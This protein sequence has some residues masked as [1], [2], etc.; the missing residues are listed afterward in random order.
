MATPLAQTV[1]FCAGLV[2]SLSAL[3]GGLDYEVRHA[4]RGDAGKVS[5]VMLHAV[6]AELVIFGASNAETGISPAVLTA[7]TGRTAY[8]LAVDGTSVEQYDALL[9]EYLTYGR[10][11]SLVI[12]VMSAFALQSHSAP[13][14]PGEY[15]PHIYNPFVYESMARFDSTDAWRARYVPFYRFA[16]YDDKYYKAALLSLIESPPVAT[17]LP[18]LTELAIGFGGGPSRGN[19]RGFVP[20]ATEWGNGHDLGQRMASCSVDE[21]V[22]E[23][24]RALI[25]EIRRFGHHTVVVFPP[26]EAEGATQI[27]CLPML[28]PVF[29]SLAGAGDSY[30]DYHEHAMGTDR[31]YFYNYTHLNADGAE[32]F[33]TILG[34]DISRTLN[35]ERP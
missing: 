5:Q 25:A 2:I 17:V 16:L 13:T 28:P 35:D 6:D 4:T 31:R 19:D 7:E 24:F 18:R 1:S 23:L 32:V 10:R 29:E 27:D 8:N 21:P 22:V 3:N 26:I 15:Y 20:H 11:G 14:A 30:L 12:L 9:R 34:K 33:S